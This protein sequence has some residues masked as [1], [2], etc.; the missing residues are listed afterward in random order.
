MS[1]LKPDR[2]RGQN[3]VSEQHRGYPLV[4]VLGDP[5]IARSQW[6]DVCLLCRDGQ[7][8]G[9][10]GL[11]A[12]PYMDLFSR[13]EWVRCKSIKALASVMWKPDLTIGGERRCCQSC[14]CRSRLGEDHIALRERPLVPSPPGRL[15]HSVA[16]P[17]RQDARSLGSPPGAKDARGFR[18]GLIMRFINMSLICW[19]VHPAHHSSLTFR[20][21]A[22]WSAGDNSLFLRESVLHLGVFFVGGGGLYR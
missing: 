17:Q 13:S 8:S 11:L 21:W 2:P 19:K 22:V 18:E 16:G 9:C 4:F 5:W 3:T 14:S 15:F 20:A 12:L 1:L 7:L 6:V 10:L